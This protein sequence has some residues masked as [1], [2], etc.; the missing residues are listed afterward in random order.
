MVAA[1]VGDNRVEAARERE[2]AWLEKQL[3]EGDSSMTAA[4][5]AATPATPATP[6]KSPINVEPN[7]L[8]LEGDG[9]VERAMHI[10]PHEDR[11]N[12][13]AHDWNERLEDENFHGIV[14]PLRLCQLTGT[15]WLTKYSRLSG[16]T[17]QRYGRL[18][19]S[20]L[21]HH[22]MVSR[23]DSHTTYR[24]TMRMGTHGTL[25][26]PLNVPS[27]S[28]I[29]TNRS[30]HLSLEVRYAQRSVHCKEQRLVNGTQITG[31]GMDVI[32]VG[33]AIW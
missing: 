20:M 8:P 2:N 19:L 30:Q 11:Q 9:L 15:A 1:D 10:E 28:D 13:N 16:T 22:S 3:R 12:R 17:C 23:Q 26:C 21:L 32:I 18:L 25:M 31:D 5:S 33:E 27:A 4:N 7:H 29:S 14:T 6:V 24:S